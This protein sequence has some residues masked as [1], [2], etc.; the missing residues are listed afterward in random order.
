MFRYKSANIWFSTLLFW[1]SKQ[2]YRTG[3]I[4]GFVSNDRRQIFASPDPCCV[5][6]YLDHFM[7]CI[8]EFEA[9]LYMIIKLFLNSS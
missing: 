3:V 1:S 6:E 5:C 9:F 4:L 8:H 7:I 2:T